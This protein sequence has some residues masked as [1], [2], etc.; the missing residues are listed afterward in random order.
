MDLKFGKLA[1]VRFEKTIQTPLTSRST[2]PFNV[3]ESYTFKVSLISKSTPK[4]GQP[5]NI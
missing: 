4:L 3:P 5:L 1:S 2:I